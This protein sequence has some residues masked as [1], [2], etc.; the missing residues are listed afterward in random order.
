MRRLNKSGFR[1][2]SPSKRKR[3]ARRILGSIIIFGLIATICYTWWSPVPASLVMRAAFHQ[4]NAVAPENYAEL[5]QRVSVVKDLCYSS[6]YQDNYADIYI[7][8]DR[9]GPFPVVLWVHGGAFVGGSKADVEIYATALAA[10]GIAVV[11]MNYRRAPEAHYPTPLVQTE[12]AYLWLNDIAELYGLDIDRLV[13]AGDSAGAHIVAQFAAI[14]SNA[15]YADEMG[16]SQAVPLH[17]MKAVLLF[18]GPFDAAKISVDN[19]AV[20]NFFIERA[21]WAYLGTKGFS[22]H[23]IEQAT[24]SNH[25]TN[26]FPPTFITDGNHLSF[27][28]HGRELAEVLRGRDVLVETYF[29]PTE[30][31]KI[32]HEYQF[33]MNTAVGRES[34]QAVVNFLEKYTD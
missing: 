6:R 4:G 17:S 22:E 11:C 5:E 28:E 19:H 3:A 15:D 23:L 12:D 26:N 29:F 10:E 21:A 13:L 31:E 25:V 9:E 20:I 34:F 27:G 2:D 14:Q 7:P 1:S 8:S 32:G 33:I 16:F 18:C 24:I 30:T